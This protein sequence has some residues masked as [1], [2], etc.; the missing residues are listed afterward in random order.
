MLA[1]FRPDPLVVVGLAGIVD[2]DPDGASVPTVAAGT[3]DRSWLEPR[4]AA[5]G[6]LTGWFADITSAGSLAALHPL[7]VGQ[8]LQLGFQDFDAA[9]LKDSRSRPLTQQLASHL[10][11]STP[12]SGVKFRSRHGDD[13]ILWAVFER[14]GDGPITPCISQIEHHALRMD[15]PDIANA[16]RM[17]GLR[18]R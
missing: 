17:L 10:Y 6:R 9:T 1:D 11:T 12:L 18:W 16:M 3:V 13:M 8:A 2:D 14:P 7:L 5:C 15:H 4:V